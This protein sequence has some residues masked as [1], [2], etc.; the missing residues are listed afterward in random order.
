MLTRFPSPEG[1]RL[2]LAAAIDSPG[3]LVALSAEV[4]S[5][6]VLFLAT[7]VDAA[8][9]QEW[10]TIAHALLRRGVVYVVLGGQAVSRSRL[11]SILSTSTARRSD[12]RLRSQRTP[13]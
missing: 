10:L 5:T 3:E 9:R 7:N 13:W 11:T 12:E 1:E 8:S 6:F 2:R 4:P